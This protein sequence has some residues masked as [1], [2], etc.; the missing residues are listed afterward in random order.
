MDVA[1]SVSS[2][3]YL[4]IGNLVF[5]NAQ[6]VLGLAY[7][8]Q[9]VSLLPNRALHELDTTWLVGEGIDS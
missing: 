9:Y 1:L 3:Y 8:G 5:R 2:T 7:L 4:I 6:N